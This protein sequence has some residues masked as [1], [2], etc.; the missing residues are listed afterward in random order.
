MT[1]VN[2]PNLPKISKTLKEK[3]EL[4]LLIQEATSIGSGPWE[5]VALRPSFP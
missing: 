2:V 1:N 4:I 5:S 3:I